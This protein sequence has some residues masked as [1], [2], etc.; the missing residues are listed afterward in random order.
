[1]TVSLRTRLTLFFVAIVVLPVTAV[2][3]LGWRAVA[4]SSDRQVR[5]ELEHS[6][7]SAMLV[8]AGQVEQAADV[9]RALAGDPALQRAMAARDRARLQAVLE[10]WDATE[11]LVAVTGPDG[12]VLA[13]AGRTEPSFLAGVVPPAP[14][15]LLAPCPGTGGPGGRG[16]DRG[17]PG[18]R[19]LPPRSTGTGPCCNAAAS[20][21]TGV[22]A[23]GARP[24]RARSAR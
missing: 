14:R 5:S 1:M 23:P 13:R 8:F 22:A 4:R 11:L 2:T 10:R 24:G 7:R 6:R 9:V 20:P 21:S 12:R 16:R 15:A 18:G 17:G 3:I 19:L